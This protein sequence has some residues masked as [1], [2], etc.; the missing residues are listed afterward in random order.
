[1]RHTALIFHVIRIWRNKKTS[2]HLT[3]ADIT[4]ARYALIKGTQ[5][6]HYA[7][8]IKQ[9]TFKAKDKTPTVIHVDKNGILQCHGRIETLK[10]T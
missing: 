6:S 9:I 1:M 8:E 4:E 2:T 10:F 5:Q 3:T 7:E